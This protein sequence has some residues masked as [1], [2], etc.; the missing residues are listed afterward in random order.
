MSNVDKHIIYG[1]L[2][3]MFQRFYLVFVV[4]LCGC[5]REPHQVE[6]RPLPKPSGPYFVK[7]IGP[8][9]TIDYYK[10]AFYNFMSSFNE[11]SP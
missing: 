2:H 7:V 11:V 6:K 10:S 8:E 3:L 5:S 4:L 9:K 1:I